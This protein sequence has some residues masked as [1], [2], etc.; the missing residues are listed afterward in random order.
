VLHSHLPLVFAAL[1]HAERA[2]GNGAHHAVMAGMVAGDRARRA[3]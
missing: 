2:S 3:H 1:A